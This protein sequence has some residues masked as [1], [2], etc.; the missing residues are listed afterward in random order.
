MA[1]WQQDC[2]LNVSYLIKLWEWLTD[3]QLSCVVMEI[4]LLKFMPDWRMVVAR[5][6]WSVMRTGISS[7]LS[8]DK[9]WSSLVDR[10]VNERDTG[11]RCSFRWDC[12]CFLLPPCQDR[13]LGKSTPIYIE[14]RWEIRSRVKR[15]GVILKS[16][17]R[18][19]CRSTWFHRSPSAKLSLLKAV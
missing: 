12:F 10:S 17:V 6:T 18:L 19:Y 16:W 2:A 4:E 9:S 11:G 1:I 5:W 7:L 13:F 15:A 8:A 14:R 3:T